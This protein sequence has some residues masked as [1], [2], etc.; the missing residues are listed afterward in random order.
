[1]RIGAILAPTGDWKVIADGARAADAAGLDAVGLW[2]HYHSA[3]PEWAHANGWSLYGALA[4]ITE[5]VRLVPMVLNN[6][7]YQPGVLAKESSMLSLLSGGRFE[8]A[9]GAGDW[10]ESYA[11]WGEPYP[12]RDERI[13]RLA[14]TV[15][16]LRLLW[17]GEPVTS[18]G[19]Y[20]HLDSATSTPAPAEPPRVVVGVGNS[21]RT[22]RATLTVA[23]EFNIYADEKLLA[24]LRELIAASDREVAISTFF[25]WSWDNWPADPAA[26]LAPWRELGVG[27]VFVSIGW[28]DMAARAEELA[29]LS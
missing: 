2:C 15:S 21:R 3:K 8:L 16:A 18:D 28:F 27:R 12:E 25:D 17:K 29:A 20:L 9:I 7:H 19:T 1:M 11:A 5:R 4:A 24:D 13:G 14:E 26:V 23:D 10:P 22:A 6:L